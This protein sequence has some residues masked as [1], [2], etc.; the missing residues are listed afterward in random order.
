MCMPFWAGTASWRPITRA[1]RY[2]K[3]IRYVQRSL[4]AGVISLRAIWYTQSVLLTDRAATQ[5]DLSTF[6][7]KRLQVGQSH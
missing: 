7:V 2:K 6:P 1:S 5:G 3:R 4:Q